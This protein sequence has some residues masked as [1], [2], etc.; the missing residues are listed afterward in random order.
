MSIICYSHDYE[1]DTTYTFEPG[2][3]R[4]QITMTFMKTC[5]LAYTAF[6]SGYDYSP[7]HK[8]SKH[9]VSGRW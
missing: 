5:T 1:N 9:W 4:S 8:K 7:N 6:D 2:A 3:E